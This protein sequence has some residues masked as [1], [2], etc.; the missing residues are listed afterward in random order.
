[1]PGAT[2]S[3][4]V[5]DNGYAHIAKASARLEAAHLALAIIE[6]NVVEEVRLNLNHWQQAR[7]QVEAYDIG[8]VGS[9]RTVVRRSESAFKAGAVNATE[10]LLTQRR[11]ISLER[12]L[13][14]ERLDSDLAW[15]KLENA[16]GGSFELPLEAPVVQV[17]KN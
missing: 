7:E 9:A 12:R 8:L 14:E 6:E 13:L 11:L 5:L 15:I 10:L 17:E 16:V 3:I 4:P 2:I 1:M